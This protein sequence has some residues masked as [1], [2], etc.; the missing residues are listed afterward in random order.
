MPEQHSH[1]SFIDTG[2]PFDF[3]VIKHWTTWT[4][5]ELMKSAGVP[6]DCEIKGYTCHDESPFELEVEEVVLFS[7]ST[8]TD[9][10]GRPI[11]LE[12]VQ[13]P[14]TPIQQYITKLKVVY[15]DFENQPG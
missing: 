8:Y 11:R 4:L 13:I 9:K 12:E 15:E 10:A 14:T 7:K 5:A 2:T 6:D 1:R 3:E